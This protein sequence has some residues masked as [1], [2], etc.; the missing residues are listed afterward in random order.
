MI[1]VRSVS[2]NYKRIV[3]SETLTVFQLHKEFEEFIEKSEGVERKWTL[4]HPLR[5]S[6]GNWKFKV[7]GVAPD[8]T[9]EYQ[10]LLVGLCQKLGMEF[11]CE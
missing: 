5:T 9:G 1:E 3:V 6:D 4:S 8:E 10:T 11:V 2:M 7:F